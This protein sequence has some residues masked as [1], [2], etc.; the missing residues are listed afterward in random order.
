M[1]NLLYYKYDNKCETHKEHDIKLICSTCKV[2]VCVECIVSEHTGHK[3]DKIDAEN[4]KAFFEEF[5]N[6]H[7]NNLEKQVDV[8]KYLLIQ[9]YNLYKSLEDKHTEN[10]NTITEEFKEL[11][12]QLSAIESEKI[13]QLATINDEN[14][15]IKENVS[16]TIK[17]NLKNI[18]LIRNKYKN[19]INQINIDQIIN[20]N[21]YTNSYQHIEIL[22]HCCQSQ[23]LTNENVLKDLMNQYKNVTIVNNSEKVKSS[24]KE[25]FE[26]SDSLSVSNVAFSDSLSISNVKDPIRYTAGGVKYYIYTDDCVVPKGSTHVAIAPSVKT[27]KVGSIPTSVEYLA[28]LDGFNVQLTE[29]MIPKTVEYLFIGAIKKPILKGSIPDGVRY[30]YL[31]DGFNQTISEL[32]E[33]IKQLLL[34][35]TPLTNFGT[36]TGPIFKSPKYKHHLTCQG[37]VDWN[38][39]GWEFKAEF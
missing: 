24:A 21:S 2:V 5:K 32:P 8:N 34:F 22:K 26:I 33:S 39:N 36:Y 12:N 25:I 28:L 6:N 19:T 38:G 9:S 11:S 27:I 15:H 35:D 23:V 16:N 20:A 10:V 1:D 31:L 17:D 3:L 37:V 29:G 7:F 13:K 4:C 18:N 30:V 14:K